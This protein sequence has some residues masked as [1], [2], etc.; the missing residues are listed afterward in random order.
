M[1]EGYFKIFAELLKYL[2]FLIVSN[3]FLKFFG[4]FFLKRL[5]KAK[6]SRLQRLPRLR[7]PLKVR[8]KKPANDVCVSKAGSPGLKAPHL[9][10]AA[11]EKF[12]TASPSNC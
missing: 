8:E 5:P 12:R 6:S 11:K 3:G 2:D 4:F 7:Q 9:K 1:K 10:K